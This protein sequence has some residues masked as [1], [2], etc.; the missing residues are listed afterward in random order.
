MTTIDTKLRFIW[1]SYH[2]QRAAEADAQATRQKAASE[3]ASFNAR[4]AELGLASVGE[5]R[6]P[7]GLQGLQAA[8]ATYPAPKTWRD[9]MW[10][11][12]RN[13]ITTHF[14]GDGQ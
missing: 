4:R 12:M 5:Y 2:S 14:A 13:T 10:D 6:D 3:L 8:W 9:E 7:S 1:D 11:R